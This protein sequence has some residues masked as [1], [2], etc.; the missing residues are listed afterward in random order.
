[1]NKFIKYLS[2]LWLSTILSAILAFLFQTSLA[3]IL[4]PFS[5]GEFNATLSYL[6]VFGS[7]AG[8][9]VDN[10][11]L[12][13]FGKGPQFG[14]KYGL[15]IIYYALLTTIASF[16]IILLVSLV[17]FPNV[18]IKNLIIL[19]PTLVSLTAFNLQ[20]AV[21]QV[22]GK[23]HQLGI[24]QIINNGIK[25][26]FLSLIYFNFVSSIYV[27]YLYSISSIIITIISL[28]SFIK[29]YNGN[30]LKKSYCSKKII[31]SRIKKITNLSVPFGLAAIAHAVYFQSDIFLLS[32]LKSPEIAG[33][34]S[35]AFSIIIATYL[36]PAVIYQK[37]LLPQIHRWSNIAPEKMLLLFQ[38][39]NGV[40]LIIGVFFSLFIF[41]FSSLIITT[42]FSNKYIQSIDYLSLLSICIPIRFMISGLGAVLATG[43]LIKY[44]LACMVFV[45]VLNAILNV[46]LIPIFGVYAAIFIKIASE[47]LLFILFLLTIFYKLYGKETFKGWFSFKKG[48][49]DVRKI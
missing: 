16:I 23:Y 35:V 34:Y 45:A 44:K 41:F 15:S 19:S 39:G 22:E 11:L 21:L 42:L 47:L 32:Y 7:L 40:M 37:I 48:L 5:F 27:Y 43:N 6:L 3:R 30:I 8:L 4:T 10:T 12:K 24:L 9:G 28:R 13:I 46:A 18:N 14:N 33:F 20:S 38:K 36:F 49:Y 26:I 17:L 29:L 31:F 25:L 2:S 1:M